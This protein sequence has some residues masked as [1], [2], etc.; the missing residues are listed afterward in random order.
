MVVGGVI[1]VGIYVFVP[2]IAAKTGGTIWLAIFSAMVVS[3]LGVLPLIQISSALPAAGGGYLW[4][5]RMLSPL[6]GT[7]VSNW[8][9]FGGSCSVAVV[10]VAMASYLQTYLDT[11][12]MLNVT[13]LFDLSFYPVWVQTPPLSVHIL[14]MIV[15]GL[16]YLVF[17]F[18]IR[19]QMT[20]QVILSAQLI[21]SLLLYVVVV[22]LGSPG[23]CTA[24]VAVT[25]GFVMG[26]AMAFNVC[27]GFQIIT[28]LGEEMKEPEKNIPL[29]LLFGAACILL[30]YVGVS[31]T[32][33]KAVGP[34]IETLSGFLST[35]SPAHPPFIE[36][37]A[38]HT[39]NWMVGFL[40]MGAVGAGLTSLNAGAIALPREIFSQARD[41]AIPRYFS[42]INKR[43]GTPL[44]ATTV[45]FGVVMVVLAIGQLMDNLGVIDKYFKGLPT[46]FYGL[47]TVYGIMLLTIF[48]SIT[49][50]RLP[51]LYPEQY[52]NA[53]FHIPKPLLYF[54]SG[55]SILTSVGL[56]V[57]IFL[58]DTPVVLYI[59][60]VVSAVIVLY[61]ILR[62][63]Y[64]ANKGE[65]LGSTFKLLGQ[66]TNELKQE[67]F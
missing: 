11:S 9:L 47:M 52:K 63:K 20:F 45:F 10:T 39:G 33:L 35:T 32:Y 8:A 46:D 44:R 2:S 56:L 42:K 30:I 14:S 53:Y 55:F 57:L 40:L 43:T 36:S 6:F 16:F 25:D 4:V 50:Y 19:L 13:S 41:G 1:G 24:S 67:L 37:A 5:G 28:E 62:V 34:D 38:Q 60:L 23:E 61:Y 49:A 48:V 54:L 51:K 27:F 12:I 58:M 15:I 7:L 3:L 29:A 59:Y 31:F 17:L 66:Q 64:L 65:Q 21:L 26:I 22:G 18:G